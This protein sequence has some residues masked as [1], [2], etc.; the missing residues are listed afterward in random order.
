MKIG[1][2]TSSSPWNAHTCLV[3]VVVSLVGESSSASFPE[4]QHGFSS[5][6]PVD[7]EWYLCFGHCNDRCLSQPAF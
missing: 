2:W 6:T 1:R 3:E 5:T 4:A 7:K